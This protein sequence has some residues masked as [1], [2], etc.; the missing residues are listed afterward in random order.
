MKSVGEDGT[1]ADDLEVAVGDRFAV[2]R[3][4]EHAPF[5]GHERREP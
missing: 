5:V 2:G 3:K 1:A 4:L